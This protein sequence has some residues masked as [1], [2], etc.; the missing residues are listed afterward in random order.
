[1]AVALHTLTVHHGVPQVGVAVSGYY[2]GEAATLELPPDADWRRL[3]AFLLDVSDCVVPGVDLK[4]DAKHGEL[5][6]AAVP[7]SSEAAG[8]FAYELERMTAD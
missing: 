2:G 8:A 1:M 6:I 7:V 5:T 3:H 4:L